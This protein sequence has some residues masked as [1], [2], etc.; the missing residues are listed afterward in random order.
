MKLIMEPGE[1]VRFQKIRFGVL[2]FLG[3]IWT[4]VITMLVLSHPR[5]FLSRF[6]GMVALILISV[7]FIVFPLWGAFDARRTIRL[8]QNST[9]SVQIDASTFLAVIITVFIVYAVFPREVALVSGGITGYVLAFLLGTGN[10]FGGYKFT[11]RFIKWLG[12]LVHR[13][14]QTTANEP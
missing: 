13:S 11:D 6:S 14:A 10:V 12:A 5:E 2:L 7:Y 8:H 3:V 4:A 9:S 1:V